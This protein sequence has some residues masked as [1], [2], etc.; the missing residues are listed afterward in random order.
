MSL[1]GHSLGLRSMRIRILYDALVRMIRCPMMIRKL[2]NIHER[3][4]GGP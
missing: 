2:E 3:L 1:R 4:G